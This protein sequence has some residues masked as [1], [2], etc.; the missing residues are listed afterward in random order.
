MHAT[1]Q[2]P[3][4]LSEPLTWAEICEQ[5]PDQHV[6]LVEVVRQDSFDPDFTTAR[7]AGCGSSWSESMRQATAQQLSGAV[8]EHRFTGRELVIRLLP[9]I[10]L[11]DETRDA[12][13]LHR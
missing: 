11:D 1:A 5:Y 10:I 9:R 6:F 4:L 3:P 7:V 13:Q 2:L 12:L 8:Y